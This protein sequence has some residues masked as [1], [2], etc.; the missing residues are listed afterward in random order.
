MKIRLSFI[1]LPIT[2]FIIG[3]VFFAPASVQAAGICGCV[4]T[5]N[6]S[7]VAAGV[8]NEKDCINLPK[9]KPLIFKTC[10]WTPEKVMSKAEDECRCKSPKGKAIV[11]KAG[12]DKAC[13]NYPKLNPLVAV[14]CEWVLSD[15]PVPTKPTGGKGFALTINQAEKLDNLNQLPKGTT[16]PK[17]IGRIIR[18]GMGL[19]GTVVFALL[20][21][22][23]VYFM[24]A[25]ASGN[26]EGISKSKDV[27]VW[28]VAG[29]FVIFS[30]YAIVD[31]VFDPFES[32]V[33]SPKV[34]SSS[35]GNSDTTKPVV[36]DAPPTPDVK[37][38]DGKPCNNPNQCESGLC[39]SAGKCGKIAHGQVCESNS[40]CVGG[41]CSKYK[42]PNGGTDYR[43]SNGGAGIWCEK[44][45]QCASGFC[46]PKLGSKDLFCSDGLGGAGCKNNNQCVSNICGGYIENL[47]LGKCK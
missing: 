29:L 14:S 26:Q 34:N 41:F 47:Q 2:L 36:P 6:K 13:A 27:L 4:D 30:S 19:L 15:A 10:S 20:I 12:G 46:N 17:L 43:C 21:F 23:G 32:S 28:T 38:K 18:A 3:F 40:E 25:S 5:A 16:L 35:S 24:V 8:A 44:A 1:T 39:N 33:S 11:V 37:L 9:T 31:M 42:L 45:D 7:T 22:G